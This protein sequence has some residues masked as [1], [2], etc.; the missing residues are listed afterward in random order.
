MT[1]SFF[2]FVATQNQGRGLP[3]RHGSG[4]RRGQQFQ[5]ADPLHLRRHG[6]LV[7]GQNG[8]GLPPLFG[9]RRR[10]QVLPTRVKPYLSTQGRTQSKPC[11]NP[12]KPRPTQV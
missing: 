12:V 8:A 9:H 2:S 4:R 6:R 10:P 7:V 11:L 3:V 1:F 5:G